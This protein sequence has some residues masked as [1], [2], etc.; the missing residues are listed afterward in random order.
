MTIDQDKTR[1]DGV[2]DGTEG[3]V[4]NKVECYQKGSDRI[5]GR[6]CP[7]ETETADDQ[8]YH[9]HTEHAVRVQS[10]SAEHSQH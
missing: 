3:R 10:P 9:C 8:E 2:T 4:V 7:L 5:V 1:N 6:S